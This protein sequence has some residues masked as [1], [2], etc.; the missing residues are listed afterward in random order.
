MRQSP[1]AEN[2][3]YY[4]EAAEYVDSGTYYVTAYLTDEE[5]YYLTES[6]AEYVIKPRSMTVKVNDSASYWFEDA[7]DFSVSLGQGFNGSVDDLGLEYYVENGEIYVKASNK[8]YELAVTPGRVIKHN[9]FSPKV[10]RSMYIS[11][12]LYLLLILA[13]VII[14]VRREDIYALSKKLFKRKVIISTAGGVEYPPLDFVSIDVERADALLTDGIAKTLI[15]RE[16]CIKTD[17]RKKCV[18]NVDTLSENFVSG[19]RVDINV[20]KER[21]LI[22]TDAGYL[23]VLGR[24]AID[25]NLRVFANAFSLSAVKM[26]VLTGGSAIITK[27]GK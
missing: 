6:V 2:G 8:N 21:G 18:I 1:I 19:E 26:I 23:K 12:L 10:T 27:K 25:K 3:L 9:R 11:L 5:N 17:G 13:A 15:M 24:G 16:D 14:V 7:S 4:F 22:P 20:L